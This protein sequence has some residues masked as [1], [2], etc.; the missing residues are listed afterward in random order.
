MKFTAAA[1]LAICA[2]ATKIKQYGGD[3]D[4]PFPAPACPPKPSASE[5]EGATPEDVFNAVDQDGSGY[6]DAKEGFEALYCMVEWG[7][8]SRDEAEAV[9]EYL[10]GFAGEDELLS[11]S[12]AHAAFAEYEGGD[13]LA[14]EKCG[15]KPSKSEMDAATPEGVFDMIDADGS[16]DI[17]E[18]EGRHALEC[19]VEWGLMT[20]DEAKA[21][22][23]YLGAAAGDDGKLDKAEA[24]AAMEALE[25]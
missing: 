10:G 19:S 11:K 16:G 2:A 17:D 22:F 9:F 25:E 7:E 14:Q 3:G 5:M 23:D 8:M 4:L 20:E 1:I 21:A 15:P 18:A 13:E 24:K 12:E 6:V